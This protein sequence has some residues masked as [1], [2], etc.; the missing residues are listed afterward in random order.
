MK[1]KSFTS[2]TKKD[3]SFSPLIGG[4]SFHRYK[5]LWDNDYWIQ[6]GE[7]LAAPR[8]KSIFEAKEKMIVR[9]TS[10]SII[11]TIIGKGFNIRN[12][13]HIILLDE[14]RRE[15]QCKTE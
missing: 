9:R 2:E 5:L 12:N 4:S 11:G 7:W 8:E 14:M 6:Y 10:D 1:E 15:L 13:T 3:D